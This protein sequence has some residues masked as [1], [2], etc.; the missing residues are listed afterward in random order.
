MRRSSFHDTAERL[1]L[2]G[3]TLTLGEDREVVETYA[4]QLETLGR[5]EVLPPEPIH[6][7]GVH[8]EVGVAIFANVLKMVFPIDTDCAFEGLLDAIDETEWEPA[9]RH[10]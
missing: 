3:N 7:K 10:A 8:D 4:D 5:C 1:R 6:A 2:I 9:R